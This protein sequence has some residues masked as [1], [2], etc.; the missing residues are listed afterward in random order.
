[1]NQELI[2]LLQQDFTICKN[3]L[4]KVGLTI[5]G[6]GIS[7]FPIFAA[8]TEA[9]DL[10]IG[11]PIIRHEELGTHYTF[12]A[13]HLEDFVNKQIVDEQKT[14]VFIDNFKDPSKYCC[15][16]CQT[17]VIRVLFLY[18]TMLKLFGSLRIEKNSTN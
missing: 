15:I 16:F 18:P 14:S 10:D 12:N 13:S 17:L 3:Y 9:I 2:Q 7:K 6:E 5:M 4:R 8:V 11:V 1:L